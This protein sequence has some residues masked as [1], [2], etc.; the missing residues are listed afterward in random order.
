MRE[1]DL[2]RAGFVGILNAVPRITSKRFSCPR[3]GSTACSFLILGVSGEVSVTVAGTATAVADRNMRISEMIMQRPRWYERTLEFRN[4][5][6]KG[7]SYYQVTVAPQP[8]QPQDDGGLLQYL[9][10]L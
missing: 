5:Y 7:K 6:I 8:K 10:T 9:H 2:P 4:M 1:S 3:Q